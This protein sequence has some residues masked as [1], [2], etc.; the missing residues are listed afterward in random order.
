LCVLFLWKVVVVVVMA[1]V[2][3]GII[4]FIMKVKYTICHIGV[5]TWNTG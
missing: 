2:C 1:V 5:A 4:I 3:Q